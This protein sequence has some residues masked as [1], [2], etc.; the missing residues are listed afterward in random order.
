MRPIQLYSLVNRRQRRKRSQ[1]L[2][3]RSRVERVGFS[4]GAVV[5]LALAAAIF[6]AGL[7]YASLTR[8][9]PSIQQVAL[10]LDSHNGALMQPTRLYDR[11]GTQLIYSLEN[12]GIPRKYL[13]VDPNRSDHFS[14]ELV[15]VTVGLL[16]RDFWD[17]PGFH[18]DRLF[19]PDPD[20]IA[21]RVALNLLLWQ[22][23]AGLTRSLR[24]RLLAAQLISQ[25][26]RPQVLEWFLNSAYFG[27]LAYGADSAARLYLDRPASDLDL[28]S[29]ALLMA[30]YQAPAL[31]PLDAPSAALDRQKSVLTRLKLLNALS[32]EEESTAKEE[33]LSFTTA[34]PES[35]SPARAFSRLVI[36]QLEARFGVER[37]ER[38]GLHVITTLDYPLQLELNCLIH[39]QML[40]LAGNASSP[41]SSGAGAGARLPDGSDCQ[42][43]RLLPTLGPA[44]NEL[45]GGLSASAVVLD[46]ASGEVLALAGDTNLSGEGDR[47]LSHSPGS[48]LSPL[49]AVAGFAR[50]TGPA[51]LTWDIPTSLPP[52]LA[53][54][55]AGGQTYH[56]PVRFRIALANDYLA[57]LAQLTDQIGAQNVWRL[58][59]AMGLASLP[60]EAG[61][62]V[63]FSG[64]SVSPLELAQV[65]AILAS[66]GVRSGQKLT[67][68]GDLQPFAALYV[69]ET[70]SHQVLWDARVPQSQ[71]VL[72]APLAYLV[73]NIL[74]DPSARW[75]SLGYPNAFE[76]GRPVG[77]KVGQVW[78]GGQSW[79]AGYTRD[80]VA[81]FWLGLPAD[82][83]PKAPL[84]PRL[85]MGMWH[86][87]MQYMMRGTPAQDWLEPE[88][89][90][91]LDVC[92]PSGMLPTAACPD[93][94]NEVFLTGS[95]PNQPDS[96]Y[97]VFQINRETGRLATI[98]T[99][100]AM[101]E[102]KTFLLAPPQARAWLLAAGLPLPPEE[103][104]AI[105][106]PPPSPSVRIDSPLAYAYVRGQVVVSGTAAGD[107]FKLYQLQAGQGLNPRDW[108]QVTQ[109]GTAPVENHTLGV[110]DTTGLDGLYALRLLVVR[111]DQTIE[112]AVIQVT[113]DNRSA[114]GAR[115]LSLSRAGNCSCR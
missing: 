55:A 25:Y 107:G 74:S 51:S 62:E 36:N 45:P 96:L 115:H 17:N 87:L 10:L 114:P 21:E 112:T 29:A 68:G 106:P 49:V 38:G 64:G 6:A 46:P 11:S 4:A 50:G 44:K 110:W 66:G 113:V 9:L 97:R 94:V 31:N 73:H 79:A 53:K 2:G 72:S 69:E 93:V 43:A 92:D 34:A 1:S 39:A 108:L 77:A 32:E 83:Q 80:R 70:A 15:R 3:V 52:D 42:S 89:I 99:P 30:V 40:R 58:A 63:L 111:S 28:A 59:E 16:D 78:G 48:L 22:E 14:P 8:N 104:D 20:T 13:A 47:L 19:S 37:V 82:E 109:E 67:Q 7:A 33:V 5:I 23:P 41:G 105:Q 61:P 56:G 24:M 35:A 98:F 91:H 86:A 76:I 12:P 18:L 26:G 54:Y 95:E 71:T 90:S 65:Y 101:V 60:E 75:P 100:P 27:H 88:G 84:D 102:G 85:S 57:P 81:L 103:Y